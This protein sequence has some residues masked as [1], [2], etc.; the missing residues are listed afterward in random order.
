MRTYIS[1]R[2]H[3]YAFRMPRLSALQSD[4]NSCSQSRYPHLP[5]PTGRAPPRHR[6][7]V[8]LI[9]IHRG[10]S[11]S[12]AVTSAPAP[13]RS[14]HRPWRQTC[15]EMTLTAQPLASIAIGR[16]T[17]APSASNTAPVSAT[18]S[19]R[20]AARLLARDRDPVLTGRTRGPPAPRGSSRK[21]SRRRTPTRDRY[22]R[23]PG[24]R[25]RRQ[26]AR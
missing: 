20:N 23:G 4:P 22:P 21:P 3:E 9:A 10:G 7:E 26:R 8:T 13:T 16:P 11:H 15:I 2:K 25:T 24:A 14:T 5:F 19:S 12:S 18:R 6:A 1:H 17:R